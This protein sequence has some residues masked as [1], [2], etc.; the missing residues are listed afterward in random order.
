VDGD[1]L[2]L[3]HDSL[4]VRNLRYSVASDAIVL[5]SFIP[6]FPPPIVAGYGGVEHLRF[7]GSDRADDYGLGSDDYRLEALPAGLDVAIDA[8]GGDDVIVIN[9]TAVL[10]QGAAVTVDGGAGRDWLDYGPVTDRVVVDLQAGIASGLS[11]VVGVENVHGGS[12]GDLLSGDGAN[13]ILVGGGGDDVLIGLGGRDLLV[14]GDGGNTLL[15][16]AG[17]DLLIAVRFDYEDDRYELRSLMAIWEQDVPQSQRRAELAETIN[18]VTIH[19]DM[20]NDF[21]DGGP[22]E[23]WEVTEF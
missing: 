3:R 19:S 7:V 17:E 18:L 14:G 8:R 1:T 4:D 20:F 12:D 22:E 21:M 15:G 9:D 2:L 11:G 10:T 6:G 16:G 5:Q 13:N 23:D